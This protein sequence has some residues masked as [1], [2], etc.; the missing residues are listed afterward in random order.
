MRGDFRITVELLEKVRGIL[1]NQ[2]ARFALSVATLESKGGQERELGYWRVR[3][4]WQAVVDKIRAW[5]NSH[6]FSY[7]SVSTTTSRR[8]WTR[9]HCEYACD[10]SALLIH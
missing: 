7:L 1:W 8:Y 4:E 9:R 6:D 2:L 5:M 3:Q 10:I